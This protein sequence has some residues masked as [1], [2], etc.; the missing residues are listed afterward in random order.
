MQNLIILAHPTQ[1]SFCHQIL[2][3]TVEIAKEMEIE[4]RIRD[5][6]EMKFNPV[7][8]HRD[9]EVVEGNEQP[10][11]IIAEQE[12][13]NQADF[14]TLI[15]PI[16]WGSMPAILK[17]Y[18]DRVFTFGFAFEAGDQGPVGMLTDKRVLVLN[19]HGAPKEVY[20]R[21]GMYEAMNTVSNVA[22]FEFTGMEVFMNKYYSSI[23]K[24]DNPTKE[25]FLEDVESTVR[26]F[27][28][29]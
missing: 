17:G 13:I 18:I 29:A 1:G 25:I 24:V 10:E 2:D 3:K 6:Y 7:M 21:Q 12:I 14:I 28:T 16:W 27:F 23:N 26:R 9:V 11:E 19:T 22:I 5:L 15:Y 4:T 8:N 20:E